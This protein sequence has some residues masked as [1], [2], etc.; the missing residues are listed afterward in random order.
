MLE[1]PKLDFEKAAIKDINQLLNQT[2]EELELPPFNIPEENIYSVP[3]S[4]YQE[5]EGQS[6]DDYGHALILGQAI[7]LNS[8][9]LTHPYSRLSTLLHEMIHL[10][11]FV[12]IESDDKG[13]EPRRA[14]L[15]THSSLK[16]TRERK[17]VVRHF[18]G[19]N[20]A[21]VSELQKRL[22]SHVI[23]KNPFLKREKEI[24]ADVKTREQAK[25]IARTEGKSEDELVYVSPVDSGSPEPRWK[26]LTF[27]YY[28]QRQVLDY[29][30]DTV[31][32]TYPD[33]FPSR[34]DVFQLFLQA[35]FGGYQFKALGRLIDDT[36]GPDAFREIGGM[37]GTNPESAYRVLDYLKKHTRLEVRK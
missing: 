14:G 26:A 29:I 16:K 4:L 37:T 2:L 35:H 5:M 30:L 15:E 7:V 23:S 13:R 34:D 3:K 12:S 36:F 19:I 8:E 10:K 31:Q 20:E 32:R 9:R 24:A 28:H 1:Y 17:R 33:E 21:V 11:G 18:I 27:P 25:K 22:F 6:D